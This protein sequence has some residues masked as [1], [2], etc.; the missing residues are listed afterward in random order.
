MQRYVLSGLILLASCTGCRMC[1][2]PFD[3]CYPVV[4]SYEPQMDAGGYEGEGEMSASNR[5]TQ[6]NNTPHLATP[7]NRVSRPDSY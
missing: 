5:P 2:N 7:K 4:Q 3:D 6:S 1:A